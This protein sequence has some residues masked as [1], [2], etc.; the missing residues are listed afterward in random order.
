MLDEIG[1]AIANE[2]HEEGL[3]LVIIVISMIEQEFNVV[4]DM[5]IEKG[6]ARGGCWF[7]RWSIGK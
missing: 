1:D 3:P 6:I 4:R 7:H 2:H 5:I